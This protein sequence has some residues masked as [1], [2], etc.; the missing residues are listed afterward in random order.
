VGAHA[1]FGESR[2]MRAKRNR[3]L[4]SLN[5]HGAHG[6]V[7]EVSAEGQGLPEQAYPSASQAPLPDPELRLLRADLGGANHFRA[8]ASTWGIS[9][10]LATYPRSGGVAA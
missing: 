5:S 6:S 8:P 10:S 9:S 1:P 3:D 4:R 7:V 2:A